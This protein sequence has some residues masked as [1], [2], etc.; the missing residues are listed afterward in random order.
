MFVSYAKLN[1]L[2]LI[3]IYNLTAK[4]YCLVLL[5]QNG[6]YTVLLIYVYYYLTGYQIIL[7]KDMENITSM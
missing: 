3:I 1:P 6:Q 5:P 7:Q 2:E 4:R